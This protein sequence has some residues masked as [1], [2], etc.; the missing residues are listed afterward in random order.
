MG[1]LKIT[2]IQ[3]GGTI[4]KDYPKTRNGWAF[5]IGDPAI[6]R[7]LEKLNP[8]FEYEII[9]VFRKDS[10]EIDLADRNQ[11]AALIQNHKSSIFIITHGTDTLIETGQFLEKK[12]NKKLIILTGA[13]RPERFTNSDAAL[14]IGTAIGVANSLKK[15]VYIAMNGIAQSVDL[16]RRDEKTDRFY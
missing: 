14:N 4:D 2:F 3:T 13:L 12:I 10:L 16:V 15:G 1:T 5:E 7:V 9:T 6:L 8:S 11:L